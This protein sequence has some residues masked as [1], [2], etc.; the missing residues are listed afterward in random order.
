M[1]TDLNEVTSSTSS[2]EIKAYAEQVI[3]E[4]EA[5]RAG[6][7]KSDAQIVSEHADT[8]QPGDK[9]KTKTPAEN[10]SGKTSADKGEETGSVAAAPEWLTDDVKAEATA[11]GIEES[12]L[13]DFT[14]REELDRAI[15]LIDKLALETG[16]K[17]LEESEDKGQP[18]DEKGQFAKKDEPKAD[19]SKEAT[20]KDGRY[21]VSLNPDLYDEEIISEFTRLRDHYESRLEVLEAHFMQSQIAAEERQ[22]DNEIDK[23]N[24]PNLFGTT[25]SET[26]EEL[27]RRE[28]VMAQ[29]RVLQAGHMRFGR[30]IPLETLVARAAPMVFATEFDKH[31]LKQRTSKISRQSQLRQGGSPVKPLPPSGDPREEADRLYRQMSGL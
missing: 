12:E 17:A 9:P 28:D 20:P 19:A 24:M 31:K 4:V 11:Y 8:P 26:A 3:K 23:L 13:S 21:Q 25:G 7:K 22:F 6:E 14:S 15:R 1:L 2:E 30:D 10:K 18:R 29:A 16:R 27:K 5:D